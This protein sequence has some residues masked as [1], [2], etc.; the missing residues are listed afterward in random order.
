MTK[1]ELLNALRKHI[2]MYE[3]ERDQSTNASFHS[4]C[5]GCIHTAL[6]VIYALENEDFDYDDNINY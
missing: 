6:T 4:F 1:E 5:R 2:K 3:Y